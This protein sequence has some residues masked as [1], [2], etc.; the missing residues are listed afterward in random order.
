MATPPRYIC[1][2]T[3]NDMD[4]LPQRWNESPAGIDDLR[5]NNCEVIELRHARANEQPVHATFVQFVDAS[6]LLWVRFHCIAKDIQATMNKYKDK[7]WKEG[8]V[9]IYL[10]TPSDSVLYEFQLSPIGTFRD[11]RVLDPGGNDQRFDD[12]W[13]C[14]HVV[15]EAR[16]N[17]DQRGDVCSWDGMFGIP[18]ES[19]QPPNEKERRNGWLLGAFR[20]EYH[21]VE[22]SAL[23]T[24]SLLDAHDRYFLRRILRF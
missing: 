1:V 19:V 5:W 15:V 2:V 7:V 18:W 16:I 21:P 17:R 10:Q 4:I 13:S 23:A 9:E 3:D 8:A 22:F 6:G 12:T 20:L 24:H 11:L 14:Q